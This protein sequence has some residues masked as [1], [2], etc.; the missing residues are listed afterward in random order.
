LGTVTRNLSQ[1]AF[2]LLKSRKYRVGCTVFA[3]IIAASEPVCIEKHR[4]GGEK[5]EDD[6]W[7]IGGRHQKNTDA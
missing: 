4:F 5:A 1:T 7:M 6:E 2:F 3:G